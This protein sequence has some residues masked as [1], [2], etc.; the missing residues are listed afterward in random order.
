MEV[1]SQCRELRRFDAYR[2]P[3]A[4]FAKHFLGLYGNRF[5]FSSSGGGCCLRGIG[6]AVI[7][8]PRLILREGTGE[9]SFGRWGYL[10]IPPLAVAAS[11]GLGYVKR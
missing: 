4:Q 3:R 6:D 10:R 8:V 11:D 1:S 2:G 9:T 5:L 7:S